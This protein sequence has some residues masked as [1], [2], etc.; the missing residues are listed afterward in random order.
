MFSS[1]ISFGPAKIDRIPHAFHSAISQ[2]FEP[3]CKALD[4]ISGWLCPGPV[5][6]VSPGHGAEETFNNEHITRGTHRADRVYSGFVSASLQ[7]GRF[8]S[9]KQR[10]ASRKRGRWP[11]VV[12]APIH[13]LSRFGL[14]C[15]HLN[16]FLDRAER[17]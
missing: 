14:L 1:G 16:G 8:V 4:P 17:V 6:F 10:E 15:S 2:R 3:T 13:V 9:E 5:S 7:F 11:P 12:P